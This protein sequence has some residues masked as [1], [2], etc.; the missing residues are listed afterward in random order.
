MKD[1]R[2][3]NAGAG[4]V[5]IVAVASLFLSARGL[6]PSLEP[7]PHEASGWFMAQE[8]MSRL[9][10][11]GWLTVVRRDTGT[12]QHPQSDLQFDAFQKALRKGRVAIGMVKTVHL[13]PLRPLE[14]PP[15]DFF[16]L[17][18]RSPPGCVIVSFMGP[19]LLSEE[20][21]RQLGESRP[22]IIAFC[23]GALPEQVD[24]RALFAAKLLEVAVISRRS[25]PPLI[26]KP[27]DLRGWFDLCY[28]KVSAADVGRLYGPI[29]G[30]P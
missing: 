2:A 22:S 24:L 15:G 26:A 1:S 16:E 8:A 9:K 23:P 11:G 18:R 20:Q 30:T 3:I 21:R 29:G 4:L 17:I 13:D 14:V 27:K 28:E 5:T 7:K 6:P 25:S 19:P 12:Y 10:P